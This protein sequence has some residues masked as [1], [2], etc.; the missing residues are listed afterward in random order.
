MMRSWVQRWDK[1]DD[2]DVRS[3][4]TNGMV[5]PAAPRIVSRPLRVARLAGRS[6]AMGKKGILGEGTRPFG[7]LPMPL[8]D[9]ARTIGPCSWLSQTMCALRE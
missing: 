4:N 7:R 6:T 9:A 5:C 8:T 3:F 1:R 2:K